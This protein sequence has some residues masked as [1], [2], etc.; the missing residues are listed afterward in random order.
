MIKRVRQVCCVLLAGAA[1]A[2]A[3]VPLADLQA[4]LDTGE[5]LLLEP[6]SEWELSAPLR[7]RVPGQRIETAGDVLPSQYAR[8]RLAPGLAG[9]IISGEGVSGISIRKL[10]LDGNRDHFDRETGTLPARPFVDLGGSGAVAQ[11]V[12]RCILLNTRCSGGWGA[13][14]VREGGRDIQVTDNVVVGSGPDLRGNG[15]APQELP[16]GWGDGISTAS[17]DSLVRNNLII[18]AT[19]QGIMVQG[20]P[21][22]LVQS[23]VVAAVSREMLAGIA[24]Y[25]PFFDYRM[26]PPEA[27]RYDYSGVVVERN[28]IDAFGGRIHVAIPM[29]PAA[30]NGRLLGKTLVGATVRENGLSG[31]A[32]GY[33]YVVNGVDQFTVVSNRSEAV[34]SGLGD[35]FKGRKPEPP[36]AFLYAPSS[37]GSSV[38][39]SEFRPASSNLV[40]VLRNGWEPRNARG[41]RS[42]GY[43]DAE[44]EAVIRAAFLE[45]LGRYPLQGELTHW[46]DWL[47]TSEVNADFLRVQLMV[48]PEFVQRFGRVSP[49]GLH[50]WRGRRWL[51]MIVEGIEKL[52]DGAPQ[53]W[54]P[55]RGL[56]AYLWVQLHVR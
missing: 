21:G 36:A 42:V 13:L 6:G 29:G 7:F 44:L 3:G 22:T 32:M 4:R 56:H 26:S 49:D 8:L 20:A 17:P 14:H 40:G 43:G 27:E 45:M 9:T 18:D 48:S 52:S 41:F 16:Y 28:L 12:S 11:T 1:V 37:V 15:T 33:G 2:M 53:E 23:N 47:M 54:P 50:A 34:F 24:L 38:L 30:W 10:V 31:H 39:Q 25:E 51:P 5:D 35:G 55:A 46:S 19:D